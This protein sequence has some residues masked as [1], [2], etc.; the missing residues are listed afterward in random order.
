MQA[1]G[2]LG[3]AFCPLLESLGFKMGEI[4]RTYPQTRFWRLLQSVGRTNPG[5]EL[6]PLGLTL[7]RRKPLNHYAKDRLRFQLSG[8]SSWAISA[9]I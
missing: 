7:R 1:W 4:R 3:P 5:L 6:E 8:S 9:Q 2:T